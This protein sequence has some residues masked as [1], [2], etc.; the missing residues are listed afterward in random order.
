MNTKT[1]RSWFDGRR[2]QYYEPSREIMEAYKDLKATE[3]W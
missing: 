1:D 3:E 2:G